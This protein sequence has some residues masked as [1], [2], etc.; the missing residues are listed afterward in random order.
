MHEM[1]REEVI[2]RIQESTE[3]DRQAEL[4]NM[5]QEYLGRFDFDKVQVSPKMFEIEITCDTNDADY[6]TRVSVISE[7]ELNKIRP[8][9]QAIKNFKP[10]ETTT[11]PWEGSA[12]PASPWIH[13]HN[14]PW[15]ECQREDLGEKS[16]REIYDFDKE[17]FD[18]FEDCC[19][20]GTYGFHTVESVK[21]CPVREKEV[22]L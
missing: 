20:Y 13:D 14:Y 15:G 6:T 19:P 4:A 17:V 9:I 21:I 3:R 11:Q 10:Y 16:P 18:I 7:E 5:P 12:R 1:D 22:L 2:R 8:L